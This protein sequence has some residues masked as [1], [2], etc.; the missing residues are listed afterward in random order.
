MQEP[1]PKQARIEIPYFDGVN[2]LV[3]YNVGKKT[4]LFHAENARSRVIGSLEKREGQT[5]VGTN[6]SSQPFITTDN[7]ALFPFQNS[8]SGMYRISADQNATLSIK[9]ND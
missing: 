4:E 7:Y 3:G 6:T 2:S 1:G 9:V 8:I 5:V